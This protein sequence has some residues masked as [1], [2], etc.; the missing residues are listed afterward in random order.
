M[1]DVGEAHLVRMEMY[2]SSTRY[3]VP[4]DRE[5]RFQRF[6]NSGTYRVKPTVVWS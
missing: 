1:A 6:S 3:D 5:N 2:V 4:I